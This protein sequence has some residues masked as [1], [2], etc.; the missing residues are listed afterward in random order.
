M[1]LGGLSC[2]VNMRF[3][4]NSV[5]SLYG[6]NNVAILFLLWGFFWL[7]RYRSIEPRFMTNKTTFLGAGQVS[8]VFI[9]WRLVDTKMSAGFGASSWKRNQIDACIRHCFVWSSAPK[10]EA[11][12]IE[13]PMGNKNNAALFLSW[14]IQDRR[15]SLWWSVSIGQAKREADF[16][17]V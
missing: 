2:G 3:F 9:A 4:A 15:T 6:L 10:Q 12:I 13:D 11:L 14:E 8:V 17:W 7:D 16:F 1:P 5:L